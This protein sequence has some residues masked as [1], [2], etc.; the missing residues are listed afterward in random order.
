MTEK[1][2]NSSGPDSEE[3]RFLNE[4]KSQEKSYDISQILAMSRGDDGFVKSL[5]KMFIVQTPLYISQIV[6]RFDGGDYKSMGE[7]AHQLKQSVYAMRIHKLKKPVMQLV[8][9]GKKNQYNETLPSQI[10]QIKHIA[11]L[12]ILELK[13][14]YKL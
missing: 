10:E 1:D 8:N 2:D 5:I 11:A 9:A 6:S 13:Q 14:D 12:V 4:F 7:T 3:D